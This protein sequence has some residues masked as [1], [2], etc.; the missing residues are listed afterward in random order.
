MYCRFTAGI[1][2]NCAPGVGKRLI[3]LLHSAQLLGNFLDF[4][5]LLKRRTCAC[6]ESLC[7]LLFRK[8]CRECALQ[9]SGAW[10]IVPKA[11]NINEVHKRSFENYDSFYGYPPQRISAKKY[12]FWDDSLSYRLSMSSEGDNS[13]SN[14]LQEYKYIYKVQ[15]FYV[16]T[17]G[18]V[19][20]SF[21]RMARYWITTLLLIEYTS[22][23]SFCWK[24]GKLGYNRNSFRPSYLKT[25]W[26]WGARDYPSFQS[27]SYPW[28][29]KSNLE[30]LSRPKLIHQ[31][32]R[33][34]CLAFH[35]CPSLALSASLSTPWRVPSPTIWFRLPAYIIPVT[36]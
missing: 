6:R 22:P 23:S 14:T 25:H 5:K 16:E 27:N 3:P 28:T 15:L 29:K 4:W 35:I 26:I 18:K 1:T 17:S 13:L 9:E 34:V 12:T 11:L 32:R 36:W 10:P 2:R 7:K 30:F 19:V 20:I 21:E 33:V 24:S 31:I 8:L